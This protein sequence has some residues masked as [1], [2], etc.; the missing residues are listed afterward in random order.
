MSKHVALILAA[1]VTALP[2]ARAA[3]EDTLTVVSWGGAYQE[4]QRKA[5]S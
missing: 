4:S 5:F 3:A 2:V 1:A